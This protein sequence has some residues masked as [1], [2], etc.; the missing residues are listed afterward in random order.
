MLRRGSTGGWRWYDGGCRL[1]EGMD[2]LGVG[3]CGEWK[4]GLEGVGVCEFAVVRI[5]GTVCDC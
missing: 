1:I 2:E 5:R 3:I 4:V